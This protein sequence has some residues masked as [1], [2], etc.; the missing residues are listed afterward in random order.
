MK[1]ALLMPLTFTLKENHRP[2][3]QQQ[4]LLI[5]RGPHNGTWETSVHD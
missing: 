1:Y 2:N 4:N 3:Y 5:M